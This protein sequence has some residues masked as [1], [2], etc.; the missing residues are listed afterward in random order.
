MN[1]LRRVPVIFALCLSLGAAL[2]PSVAL[3]A[4]PTFGTPTATATLGEP[5]TFSSTINGDDVAAVEV[6]VRLADDLTT[7]VLPAQAAQPDGTWQVTQAIDIES[8]GPCACLVDGNSAPNTHFEFQFRVH[9]HDGST[10]LGPLGQGIVN[11]DRFEWRTLEQGL[12]RVHWYNGDDAFARSAADLANEAIDK[13]SQLLGTT[14][15]HPV[16]IYVYDTEEALRSAV[17]PNRENIQAEAHPSIQTLFAW[18]PPD[19]SVPD[20]VRTVVAHELTHLVFDAATSNPYRGVPRWLNEGVAVYLS[21]GYNSYWSSIIDG[22]V[23]DRTLIP[24]DGL[25]GFFPSPQDQFYIAYA[26]AVAAIDFFIRTYGEQK[27]WDLVRSYAGGVTDDQAFTDATGSDTAAFNAA[28][29]A[30]LSVDV[31]A[32]LGPQPGPAGPLPPEWQAGPQTPAPSAGPGQSPATA[33]PTVAPSPQPPSGGQSD[34]LGRATLII[35]WLVAVAALA[36]LI[37]YLLVKRNRAR[38][39]PQGW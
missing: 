32:P 39:P 5:I 19:A 31:P 16:D 35:A 17:A 22:A 3:A 33:L 37:G 38:R 25:A 26:E 29:F 12:V 13:A 28:W 15:P 9:A 8:S 11:D 20:L 36:A 10:T 6:L 7:I 30:S 27:L 14:L 2:V 1:A 18:I 24:L 34:A 4:E 23:G 21:E